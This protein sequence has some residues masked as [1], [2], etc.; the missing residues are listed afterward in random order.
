MF[1]VLWYYRRIRVEVM[2]KQIKILSQNTWSTAQCWNR[3]LHD[4]EGTQQFSGAG[5]EMMC[6]EG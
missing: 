1:S 6:W 3:G 5:L 2:R 4:Y